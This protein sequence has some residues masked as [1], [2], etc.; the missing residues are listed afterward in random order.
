MCRPSSCCLGLTKTLISQNP[1]H[2][3][4][5][6]VSPLEKTLQN[7]AGPWSQS[8][9][10]LDAACI[11][12]T[13]AILEVFEWFC[14]LLA[15]HCFHHLSPH[16]W[17]QSLTPHPTNLFL[18]HHLSQMLPTVLC[19][20]HNL[21]SLK[22]TGLCAAGGDGVQVG[23][24]FTLVPTGEPAQL[25]LSPDAEQSTASSMGLLC[26][27]LFTVVTAESGFNN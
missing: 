1:N 16:F 26:P 10:W 23:R 3:G 13:D 7:V 14:F 4:D 17:F 18:P 27:F 22:S 21:Q 8:A 11:S 24:G 9:T 15:F 25:V 19:W 2:I 12:G 20:G 6:L 5:V